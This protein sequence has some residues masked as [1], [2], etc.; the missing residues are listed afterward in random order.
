MISFAA[1]E[2]LDSNTQTTAYSTSSNSITSGDLIIAFIYTEPGGS[3]VDQPT[4]AG[5][6]GFN[7][8]YTLISGGGDGGSVVECYAFWAVASSSTAGVI[9]FTFPDNRADNIVYGFFTADG[10][11]S[12]PIVSGQAGTGDMNAGSGTFSHGTRIDNF[13][14]SVRHGSTIGAITAGNAFVI[15]GM[16]NTESSLFSIDSGWTDGVE[17]DEGGGT[18][19]KAAIGYDIVGTPDN[20]GQLRTSTSNTRNMGVAFELAAD[21]GIIEAT[22][23]DTVSTSESTIGTLNTLPLTTSYM[24]KRITD[25]ASEPSSWDFALSGGAAPQAAVAV[26]A[27]KVGSTYLDA[28]ATTVVGEDDMTPDAPDLTTIADGAMVI[29]M[30]GYAYDSAAPTGGAPSGYTLSALAQGGSGDRAGVA[31]AYDGVPTAGAQS[32]GAWTHSPDNAVAEYH[33]RT[34]S[35]APVTGAA[36]SEG[37]GIDDVTASIS[38]DTRDDAGV[39]HSDLWVS[40]SSPATDGSILQD[41][42]NPS[43]GD[44]LID[45]TVAPDTLHYYVLRDWIDAGESEFADSNE[46][47][48]RTAPAKPTNLRIVNVGQ[49]WIEFAW[50][51]NTDQPGGTGPHAH[52]VYYKVEGDAGW[53]P[54]AVVAAGI[55]SFRIGNLPTA[56]SIEIRVTAWNPNA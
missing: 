30:H 28:A 31:V 12:T 49:R 52:R 25:V 18:Y 38:I 55:N 42:I 20:T 24:Y 37:L 36:I 11:D 3:G 23:A 35:L 51:D 56:T 17:L 13:D 10:V 41:G 47:A 39:D 2:I 8:T 5:T 48:I 4:V 54:P 29:T 40:T 34:I 45:G 26:A 44:I 1:G 43:Q 46:V 15:I 22:S 7:A 27:R 50:D 14:S 16:T 6:N 21:S 53:L 19:A 32:I 9:T 33:T